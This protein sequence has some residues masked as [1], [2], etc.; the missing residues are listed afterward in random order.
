MH[1][2][3]SVQ[4]ARSL[5]SV[6][7]RVTWSSMMAQRPIRAGYHLTP[8]VPCTFGVWYPLLVFTLAFRVTRAERQDCGELACCTYSPGG[9]MEQLPPLRRLIQSKLADGRLPYNSIPRVWG[10]AGNG[11]TCN[12]CDEVIT[13]KQLLMEGI[14]AD[15]RGF[16]FHVRCFSVWDELRQAPK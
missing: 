6:Q 2:G 11:E 7:T 1:S 3:Q 16:Q 14:G 9:P 4:G 12:A 15:K 8:L 13:K 10:G 5:M